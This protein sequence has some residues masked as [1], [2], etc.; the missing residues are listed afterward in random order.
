MDG[1]TP[2][3][4]PLEIPSLVEYRTPVE[5]GKINKCLGAKIGRDPASLVVTF[6][7]TPLIILYEESVPHCTLM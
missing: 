2:V 4:L 5:W 3:L 7:C 1:Y 6:L